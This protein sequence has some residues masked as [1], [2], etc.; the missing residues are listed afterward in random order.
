MSSFVAQPPKLINFLTSVRN[1][2]KLKNVDLSNCGLTSIPNEIF[3]LSDCLES[4]NLGSNEL[5]TLPDDFTKMNKLKILFF[6]QNCFTSIPSVLG[7]LPSLFMLSFKSNQVAEISEDCLSPSIGWLILTDN[8]I[9]ELPNSIGNLVNLRKLMLTGNKLK[10]LPLT[11]NNCQE[12]ELIRLSS[13]NLDHIP[14]WLLNL[15]KLSWIACSGNQIDITSSTLNALLPKFI[16]FKNIS[17]MEQIGEGASGIVYRALWRKNDI[18]SSALVAVKLF[19]KE[20]AITSDGKPENE[21]EIAEAVGIHN[22]LIPYYGTIIRDDGEYSGVVMEYIPME[23]Y[24]P[25][26]SPPSFQSV[27]KD[28]YSNRKYSLSSILIIIQT[29]SKIMRHLHSLGICHGDLYGHN[30][31]IETTEPISSPYLV[32]FGAS[33]FYNRYNN[34]L[35]QNIEKIEVRAFGNLILELI[36]LH[37]EVG[38]ERDKEILSELSELANH[39]CQGDVLLRRD[40]NDI[41]NIL[42]NF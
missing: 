24:I 14:N 13:N 11:L 36:E 33:Y 1:G 17:V 40:F 6:A 15:P 41:V 28:V 38:S 31:L 3:S 4:L 34:L 7:S 32:D 29:I 16:P 10:D 2:V 9:I 35:S 18:E 5:T 8:N 26:A 23:R 22:G 30:I 39:C 21:I 12:L 27:T 42:N 19:K 20:T 25:L 37:H